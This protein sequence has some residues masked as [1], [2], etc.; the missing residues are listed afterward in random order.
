MDKTYTVKITR[1]A[2][3][4]LREI[5]RYIA[6]DLL[7]PQT[8]VQLIE[9][10]RDAADSL[11]QMPERIMLGCAGDQGHIVLPGHDIQV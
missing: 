8:A 1:H 5:A 4:S 11:S 7:E 9:K 10:L 2:E 3:E 6:Y